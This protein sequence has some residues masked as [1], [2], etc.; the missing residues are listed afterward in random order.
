[1]AM[2]YL[3]SFTCVALL[4]LVTI[5][6]VFANDNT[7]DTKILSDKGGP[8]VEFESTIRDFGDVAPKSVHEFEYRFKNVGDEPLIISYVQSTCGCTIPTLSKKEY[9][10]GEK[11]VIKVKYTASS[12][13]GKV[14]KK[15]YFHSND[16]VNPRYGLVIKSNTVLKVTIKPKRINLSLT[17]PN[18]GMVPIKIRSKDGKDFSILSVDG[19]VP[20]LVTTDIDKNLSANEFILNPVV[21]V[22]KLEKHLNGIIRVKINHPDCKVVTLSYTT[23]PKFSISP[24]RIL[25]LEAEPGQ[26][27][28]REIMIKTNYSDKIEIGSIV[29]KNGLISV[30][31]KEIDGPIATLKVVIKAPRDMKQQRFFTDS[32]SVKLLSGEELVIK[33]N[34][35]FKKELFKKAK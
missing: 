16:V 13:A 6:G 12:R 1:M 33:C 35:W 30:V 15:I 31:G 18:C 8:R 24:A 3:K 26:S 32:L 2:N 34:G 21:D 20:G 29:S 7:S 19:P 10:P 14:T 11:G 23:K 25:F 22:K 17:A 28:Q 9:A 4:L 5:S 27:E